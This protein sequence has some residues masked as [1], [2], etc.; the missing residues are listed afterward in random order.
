MS[1]EANE[2]SQQAEPA[3]AKAPPQAPKFDPDLDLM[4]ESLRNQWASNEE[5]RAEE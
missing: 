1:E 3:P 5:R 4:D 2:Q